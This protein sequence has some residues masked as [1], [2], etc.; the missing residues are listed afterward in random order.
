MHLNSEI[1]NTDGKR[2]R[3]YFALNEWSE[4]ANLVKYLS[5][6]CY[7]GRRNKIERVKYIDFIHLIYGTSGDIVEG[8]DNHDGSYREHLLCPHKNQAQIIGKIGGD[9]MNG[10]GP[11]SVHVGEIFQPLNDWPECTKQID[12]K[13][14]RRALIPSGLGTH[15]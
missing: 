2:S 9:A 6:A 1:E 5:T 11:E 8:C 7:C 10:S 12:A 15:S 14:R 4:S 13:E 3:S